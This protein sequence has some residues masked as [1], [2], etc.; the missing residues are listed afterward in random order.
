MQGFG[1]WGLT[2]GCFAAVDFGVAGL[3]GHGLI[4]V[5]EPSEALELGLQCPGLTHSV[6]DQRVM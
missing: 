1:P 5:L 6:R 4:A 2:F 3:G